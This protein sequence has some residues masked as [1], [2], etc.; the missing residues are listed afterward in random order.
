MISG[1]DAIAL[2][3]LRKE[4]GITR[5]VASEMPV[6]E[7]KLFTEAA[8]RLSG[9]DGESINKREAERLGMELDDYLL[10]MGEH[11]NG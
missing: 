8:L 2:I 4:F 3:C 11:A 10:I 5:S 1:D 9:V 6:W 7:R